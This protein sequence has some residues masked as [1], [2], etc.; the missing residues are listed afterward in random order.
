MGTEAGQVRRLHRVRRVRRVRRVLG[1]ASAILT[2][3]PA[4]V[5]AQQ[6]R[7]EQLEQ[8]RAERARGAPPASQTLIEKM[9][10]FA[11]DK[12]LQARGLPP[13][14]TFYPLVRTIVPESGLGFGGGY[15]RSL[16]NDDL[17][18]D[19]HALVSARGYQLGRIELSLPR[20]VRHTIE[21]KGLAQYRH[22]P[23]EDFFGLG[24]DARTSDRT[25]YLLDETEYAAQIT[26]RPRRWLLL[27]SQ[28]AAL[29]PRMGPG[30]DSDY[31]SLEARFTEVTAP[32]STKRTTFFEHGG[33]GMID[34]RDS[35][36]HPRSGGRYAVYASRYDD[37]GNRG[38]DFFRVAAHVEQYLPI[39]DGKRVFVLRLAANHLGASAGSHVPIYY[40]PLVGGM[41]SVR[42]FDDLRFRDANAWVLTAEYRWEA[43]SGVGLALLYDLGG[44][45]PR[46]RDLS[47]GR[48]DDA[49]G[50]GVRVG[51]DTAIFLRAEVA[52]G[53]REGSRWFVG[54]NTPLKVERYLR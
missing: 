22:L 9:L 39:F 1:W 44:V 34:Y 50:F 14:G 41:N 31:P 15:R 36:G 21:I 27:G 49:F 45:A 6:T 16:A 19:V 4:S 38:L 25:N 30:A 53:A 5:F 17:R 3:L 13:K 28:H 42:G 40:M 52:Y 20:L 11:E 10:E 46:F 29:R 35:T 18:F 7:N 24:P 43:I 37:R 2:L 12:F 33:L 23:E 8:Q 47:I 32:G 26:W 51:T 48:A 54:L